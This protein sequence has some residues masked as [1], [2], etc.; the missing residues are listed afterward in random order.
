MRAVVIDAYGAAPRLADVP[1]A[2]PAPSQIKVRVAAASLNPFDLTIARGDLRDAIPG[3][4]PLVLGIDAAGEVVE[5]GGDVTGFDVGE[6]VYGVFFGRPAGSTGTFAE[7]V[8]IAAGAP[9]TRAP[10]TVD[11]AG[12]AS[13]PTAGGTAL[14]LIETA[15]DVAGRTMLV[16][17]AT[18]G[19]GSFITQLAAGRG[20]RVIATARGAAAARVRE[21]GAVEVIDYTAAPIA[22]QLRDLVPDGLDLYVHLARNS[23][24]LAAIAAQLVGGG[25]VFSTVGGVDVARLADRDVVWVNFSHRQ[26]PELLRRLADLLDSGSLAVPPLHRITL[27]EVPAALEQLATGHGDGKT[28]ALI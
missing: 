2:A 24:D 17:G 11:V 22:D 4:F 10:A 13:L 5:A 7:Y 3:V 20:A 25:A 16:L 21:Y 27:E 26:S 18:G 14:G 1:I 6:S 23:G 12:A 15:G 8:T 9:V 28:V 19:V